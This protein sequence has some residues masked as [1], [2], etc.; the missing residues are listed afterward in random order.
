MKWKTRELATRA[1][2]LGAAAI[3]TRLLASPKGE[4]LASTVD[5]KI[6]NK[7]QKLSNVFKRRAKNTR[8]HRGLRIAGL[9]ALAVG[10]ALL[11]G[12]TKK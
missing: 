2:G 3:A 9:A 5:R 11:A 7:Q 1:V 8:N 4:F 10:A 6:E 12:S